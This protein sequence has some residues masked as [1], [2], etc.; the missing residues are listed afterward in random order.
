[1]R[2]SKN[3]VRRMPV[4]GLRSTVSAVLSRLYSSALIAV[5]VLCVVSCRSQA[6]MQQAAS[7]PPPVSI[8]KIIPVVV[9]GDSASLEANLR[10][11][12]NGRIVMDRLRQ[13]T[14]K[15]MNL[16]AQIDSLGNLR[17]KASRKPD[18]VFTKGNDSLIYVPVPGPEKK[19]EVN[20][21]TKWQKAMIWIGSAALLLLAVL[22][23]P[24]F[25][26]LILTLLKRF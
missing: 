21:L 8:P 4:H 24:K 16:Q 1:M 2:K 6:T 3:S 7:V 17:V 22:G 20:V 19:V 10:V 26:K 14:S 5:S 25:F 11:D 9:D 12:V 15:R 23:I 18:T 13:E